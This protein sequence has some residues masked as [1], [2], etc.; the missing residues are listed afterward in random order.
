MG[1]CIGGVWEEERGREGASGKD[2]VW[3][4]WDELRV[5]RRYKEIV[6]FFF[7]PLFSPFCFSSS[8]SF[9]GGF[10]LLLFLVSY[11]F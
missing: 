4:G 3:G 10:F 7:P 5:G 11:L 6:S 9:S 2:G 1:V 8:F